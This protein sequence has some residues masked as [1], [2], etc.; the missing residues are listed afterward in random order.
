MGEIADDIIE[1]EICQECCCPFYEATGY[2]AT[3]SDCDP[4]S[5]HILWTDEIQ[6]R[7]DILTGESD[8]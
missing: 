2:P 4:N 5:T 6:R 8:G 1:G 7:E 3:C